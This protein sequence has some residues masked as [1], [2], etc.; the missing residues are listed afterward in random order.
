MTRFQRFPLAHLSI[1]A[2]G[3]GVL[4]DAIQLGTKYTLDL[5]SFKL[6]TYRCGRCGTKQQVQIVLA[7]QQ[8][9]PDRPFAYLP[10][11]LFDLE[12]QRAATPGQ[13]ET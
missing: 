4:D 6:G 8:L 5:S 7:S 10:A 2:C 12:V 11:K 9:N 1:C 13:R 3:Y